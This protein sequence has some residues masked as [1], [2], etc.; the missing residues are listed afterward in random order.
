MRGLGA[1][2]LLFADYAVLDSGATLHL[3]VPEAWAAAVWRLGRG[4][5][6]LP[7]GPL[8]T[9]SSPEARNVGLCD[10]VIQGDALEWLEGWIRGRSELALDTAAMLIRTRGGDALERAEFAS[11]FASGEPQKGMAAFLVSR[12]R[13]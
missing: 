8:A 13:R 6:R 2:T 12:K 10:E 11:L 3:D 7:L 4:A 9:L 5:L 1:A